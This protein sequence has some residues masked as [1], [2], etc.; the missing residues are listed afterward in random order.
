[1]RREEGGPLE[2]R[3]LNFVY[4]PLLEADGAVSGIFVHGVDVTELVRTTGALREADRRKDEFL[5]MLAHELR[6]PLAPIRNAAADPAPAGPDD[7]ALV[8]RPRGMID[9]QVAHLARLVDDLLDVSRI[10]R[11]KILLRR[12]AWTWPSWSATPS[13]TTGALLEAGA[14]RCVDAARRAGLGGRAT[15]RGWRRCS[16][17]CST[18]PASSPTPAGRVAVDWRRPSG[19]TAVVARAGHRDRHRPGHAAAPVRGVQPRPTGPWTGARA[20]SGLGLALVKGLVD[21]HGGEVGPTAP[22]WDR[23]RVHRPAAARRGAVKRRRH[24]I[25]PHGAPGHP[26]RRRF[27]RLRGDV[28]GAA[29]APAGALFFPGSREG[30]LRRMIEARGRRVSRAAAEGDRSRRRSPG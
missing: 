12:S 8:D 20:G 16:T 22:G 17:T 6:N 3:C 10:A 13:R 4:Q 14:W 18:T 19:D 1:M 23:A 27:R 9:R 2:Q 21:L 7:A 28:G 24:T 11:G 29:A 25:P 5:A 30:S 15:R 26:R